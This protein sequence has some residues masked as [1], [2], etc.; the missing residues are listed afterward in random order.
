MTPYGLDVATPEPLPV[1]GVLW[2]SAGKECAYVWAGSMEAATLLL[3]N[4]AKAVRAVIGGIEFNRPELGAPWV[5][6]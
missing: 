5:R 2:D 1:R 6:S 4:H 3:D